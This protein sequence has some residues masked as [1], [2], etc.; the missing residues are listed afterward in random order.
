MQTKWTLPLLVLGTM[1]L[2]GCGSLA[3]TKIVLVP[4]SVKDDQGRETTILRLM[5]PTE[6]RV[7]FWNSETKDWTVGRDPVTLPAGWLLL[8]PPPTLEK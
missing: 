8:S 7:G 4:M 5:E 6:A 1:W 3:A 2:A